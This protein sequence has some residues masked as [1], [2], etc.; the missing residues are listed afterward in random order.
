VR[1]LFYGLQNCGATLLA[2]LA[3]QRPDS[4]VVPDLWTMYA[5][6]R[7]D[8]VPGDVCLKATVTTSFPLAR[9]VE[10]FRPDHVFVVTRRPE[11][12]LVSLQRKPYA[13]HDGTIAE[14]FEVVDSVVADLPAAATHVL[15]EDVMQDPAALCGALADLGWTLPPDALELGRTALDMERTL[16]EQAPGLYAEVQWGVGEARPD[17]LRG[18]VPLGYVEDAAATDFCRRHSPVLQ[19]LY[20]DRGPNPDVRVVRAT[21]SAADEAA[22]QARQ[23]MLDNQLAVFER[24]LRS[25]AREALALA[26]EL[27]AWAPGSARAWHTRARALEELGDPRGA[28]GVLA[29]AEAVV[30]PG[31][32]PLL[33]ELRARQALRLGDVDTAAELATRATDAEPGRIDGWLLLGEI[34]LRRQEWTR[35]RDFG[36]RALSILPR[37]NQALLVMARAAS[38]AGDIESARRILRSCL[39]LAPDLGPAQQLLQ[40]LDAG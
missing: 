2:M 6:P 15:F 32:R 9:H 8:D 23:R 3:G 28:V 14:K 29:D 21:A 18:P 10:R 35:A 20:E 37:S 11:D 22:L 19:R 1:I 40:E 39:A 36:A 12:N 13:N 26:G 31:D 25:D 7:A 38:R 4:L 16:W 5:A 30:D 17:P 24:L 34:A 27:C 33:R